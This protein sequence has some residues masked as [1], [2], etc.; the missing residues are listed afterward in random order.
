MRWEIDGVGVHGECRKEF[1]GG[2]FD[3]G[4]SSWVSEECTQE[5]KRGDV[6][7]ETYSGKCFWK[8]EMGSGNG[9]GGVMG[10]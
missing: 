6:A 9:K 2:G 1:V 10:N 4:G 5:G 7:I 8:E 3:K